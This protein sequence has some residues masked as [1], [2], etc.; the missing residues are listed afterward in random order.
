M[1]VYDEELCKAIRGKKHEEGE[2]GVFP[3]IVKAVLCK[4]I[5]AS[6]VK[7]KRNHACVTL[8][9]AM[10]NENGNKEKIVYQV[11]YRTLRATNKVTDSSE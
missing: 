4:Q 5:R 7:R 1:R 3:L 9:Q 2:K 10:A 8:A 11:S 6:V